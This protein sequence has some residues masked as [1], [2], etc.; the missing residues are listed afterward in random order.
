M[1]ARW[2]YPRK[3]AHRS[4]QVIAARQ[5]AANLPAIE[6][7]SKLW[8]SGRPLRELAVELGV[9]PY[10]LRQRAHRVRR[11]YPE[12]FPCRKPHRP[13][14]WAE[15]MPVVDRLSERWRAG[16]AVNDLAGELGPSPNY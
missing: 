1:L 7:F 16:A 4:R 10:I 5:R 12:K 11:H 8:N 15:R 3:S 6:R 13:Q 14:D 2:S 9:T